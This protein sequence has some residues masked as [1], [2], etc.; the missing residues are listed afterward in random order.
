MSKGWT[1]GGSPCSE[2]LWPTPR[3]GSRAPVL[4]CSFLQPQLT[5]VRLHVST[6]VPGTSPS[7][8]NLNMKFLADLS[9]WG[10][11]LLNW[12]FCAIWAL[13]L[14]ALD[15]TLWLQQAEYS[16]LTAAPILAPLDRMAG[17]HGCDSHLALACIGCIIYKLKEWKEICPETVQGMWSAWPACPHLMVVTIN[18]PRGVITLLML[19]SEWLL[20]FSPTEDVG[21]GGLG[22]SKTPTGR[23]IAELS[24]KGKQ[25][26]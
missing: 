5:T 19:C 15:S 4:S 20:L 8:L 16:V 14:H 21:W 2:A 9:V 25:F 1:Y 18:W 17:I 23:R 24:L 6:T 22:C 11:T 12:L 7:G 13:C 26:F 3:P 10:G